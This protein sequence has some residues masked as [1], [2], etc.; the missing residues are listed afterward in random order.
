MEL[1]FWHLPGETIND[2]RED[3]DET[4]ANQIFTDGSESEQGFGSV[5]AIFKSGDYIASLKYRLNKRCANNQAE[6]LVI[7]RTLA[8][9]KNKQTEDMT[10]TIYTDSQMTLN[11]LKTA[12]STHPSSEK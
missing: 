8:Y 5:V 6:Q 4:S 7:L 10:Y 3:T 1:K 9:T 12:T 11:S 2:F